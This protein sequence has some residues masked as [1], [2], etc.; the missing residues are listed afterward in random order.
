MKTN[1][2]KV[3]ERDHKLSDLGET[4]DSLQQ[5]AS[6]FEQQTSKLKR[7]Y[8]LENMKV[9]KKLFANLKANFEQITFN[10]QMT[11]I[12]CIIG[13]IIVTF[14]SC[15]LLI[16]ST[17]HFTNLLFFRANIWLK[18]SREDQLLRPQTLRLPSRNF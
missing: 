16:N 4:A 2:E 13:F 9:A 17:I 12:L 11:I 15:K 5:G 10:F 1:V 7:K 8:Y 18:T 14:I 6:H 3:L